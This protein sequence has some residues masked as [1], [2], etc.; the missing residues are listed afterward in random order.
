VERND[1]NVEYLIDKQ[2]VKIHVK[3][4]KMYTRKSSI[5]TAK[6]HREMEASR[7]TT[8]S[9]PRTR[10]R[11][12]AN[13]EAEKNH[14]QAYRRAIYQVATLSF[15]DNI[16][17][18]A[19]NRSDVFARIEYE[20]D[21]V[22]AEAKYHN[23]CYNSFLRPSSGGKIGRPEDNSV[24]LAM[25]EIFVYIENNDDCQFS[26]KELKGICKNKVPDD[27]TIKKRL[28]LKY[29]NRI[30]ITEKQGSLTIIC[31]I[32]KQ[33]D[34]LNKVWYDSKKQNIG[35]ERFRI[36]KAA[37]TILREDIQSVVC[38]TKNYPPP[39]QMFENINR[40]IPES[41]TYFLELLILKN[42]RHKLE[43]LKLICTTISH[44]IMA[45]IR[46]RS[47]TMMYEAAAVFHSQPHILPPESGIFVQYAADNADINVY[48]IDGHNTLHIMA[49]DFAEKAHIPIQ[50]YQNDGVVG[51]S[52]ITAQSFAYENTMISLL[53]KI[54]MVWLYGKW[55]NL[56]LPGWN[57]YI[58]HLPN[59]N[60]DFSLS[61]ILFLPFVHQ[62]ASNYNTIY[63]TLLC[64]L[65]NAKNYGH[66]VCVITFD[67][68]LYTKA[69]EIVSA[70]PEKSDLS[71]IVIRL[72]GFHLL[73]SFFGTIG[74]IMQGSGIKEVLSLIY[75][76]NSLDKML[77]GHAYARAVRAHTLLH[78]TLSTIISKELVIDDEMNDYLNKIQVWL[79]N[80]LNPEDWGWVFKD[81]GLEPV[82]TLLPPAP[83]KLLNTIFCNC[84]KGCSYNCG[85][86]KVGLFCSLVCNNCRGQSCSNVEPNIADNEVNDEAINDETLDSSFLLSQPIHIRLQEDEESEEEQ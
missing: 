2:S 15:K 49:K 28:K 59:N 81:N 7:S 57:G 47:N 63:T 43:N 56:S 14:R 65:E 35:E 76:P 78:L 55:N 11:S 13:E 26:L 42:K 27:K 23:N 33:Y 77:N 36:L 10:M 67:Q 70:A 4:R 75:A 41:L 38:D 32:D 58:E 8:L 60:M 5:A 69:Q 21:L 68:P 12:D 45:A 1:G 40:E 72:G 19:T 62:P 52:K 30:I 37:A 73:M 64:A 18:V 79:G 86:K 80:E 31:F 48:T 84:K 54:D 83:E 82:Q 50:I 39:S 61:K 29:D 25:E 66:D 20:Y 51:Y 24:I 17:K 85:C 34:V 44:C 46:P 9:P 6:R 53:R 3:C 16:I 74:Y 71:K 22:A